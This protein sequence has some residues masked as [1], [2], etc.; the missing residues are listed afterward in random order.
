MPL[1][2]LTAVNVDPV[3][4][5]PDELPASVPLLFWKSTGLSATADRGKAS[6]SKDIKTIRFIIT[7]FLLN[8]CKTQLSVQPPG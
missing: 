2:P 1:K 3:K 6:A 4:V 8:L 7:I 5:R